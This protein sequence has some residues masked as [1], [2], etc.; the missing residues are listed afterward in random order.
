MSPTAVDIVAELERDGYLILPEVVS[1]EY[2]N[3]AKAELGCAIER[4]VDYHGTTDYADYGMVLVCSLY[5]GAFLELFE[6]ESLL[7]PFDVALGPGCIVYAYTSSSMPPHMTNYSG[8]IHVDCPRQ[9]PGYMTNMGATI[10]LDDFT[11]DN[12]ATYF[13]PG[14]HARPDP[15][16]PEEF[17]AGAQRLLAP[18]GSVFY[19]N[20]RLWH[21]GGDN[22]TDRWR[23]ALTINMCRSYMKQRIDLPRAMAHMDLGEVPERVLQ[24]LG[25][26]AQV[27]ASYDE[28]YQPPHLRKYSQEY[29]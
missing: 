16:T 12:G 1:G 9:I 27:P 23:H 26:R 24:K 4:E 18:A 17:Q 22:T 6:N 11:E 10:L 29:E 25:F 19:F 15:P 28:Y 3:R 5:G 7:E 21:R 2:V 14:S 20:A 8:R 13:L